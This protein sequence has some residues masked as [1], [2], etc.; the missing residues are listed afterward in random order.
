MNQETKPEDEKKQPA[1]ERL[2]RGMLRARKHHR[3]EF[4]NIPRTPIALVLDGVKGTYNQGAIFRLCDAFLLEKVHVCGAPI[5]TWRKRF[6]KAAR[7]TEK[8]VDYEA[9]GDALKTVLEYGERG[10]QI[11]VVEQ[12]TGSVQMDDVMFETPVCIVL[13]SEL[14]G[15]SPAV[16]EAA[17]VVIELPT[18]GMAN[19][20]NVSM[21]A[22][23][24]VL[25][26]YQQ[27]RTATKLSER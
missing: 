1:V 22:G 18:L 16:V 19:S 11:V 24:L 3:E 14:E 7:G 15:V 6:L 10:Y 2:D 23:M 25:A 4:K 5:E 12:C 8:W 20:L 26:V 13:G 17:D 27:L 21:S 9:G